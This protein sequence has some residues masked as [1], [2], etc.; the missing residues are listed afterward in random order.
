MIDLR[1]QLR[2]AEQMDGDLPPSTYRQVLKDLSR[3]NTLTLARRP[4]LAFLDRVTTDTRPLR[5]LDV[6]FG[7]GDML[8]AIARRCKRKGI[9]ATLVGIDLNTK[10][11]AVARAATPPD[12]TIDYR[13]GDY[14]RLA[15]EPWD[16]VISSLVAHHMDEDEL[17][18]FLRFMDRHARRGWFIN[19]LHRLPVPYFGYPVLARVVGLHPIVADDGRLSIARSFRPD[20]W[21]RLL[22]VAGISPGV[23][24]FRVFPYRL[25]VERIR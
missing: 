24:V 12:L 1:V 4:T 22:E 23:R 14:A 10:S 11:A 8:R 16:V 5:V 9:S 25:C 19:D 15:N 2:A 3:A 20:D 6:G 18:T 21:R 13:S 17:L 7:S